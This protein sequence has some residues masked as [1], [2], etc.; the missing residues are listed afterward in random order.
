MTASSP[1]GPSSRPATARYGMAS[2]RT[3]V[4]P[5]LPRARHRPKCVVGYPATRPTFRLDTSKP[6]RRVIVVASI[7]LPE[8]QPH[9]FAEFRVQVA[10]VRTLRPVRGA[11]SPESGRPIVLAGDLN[12]VPTDFDI[13]NP[14]LVARRRGDATGSTRER[15]RSL[16]S[17]GWLD[18]ARHLY[19][20]RADVYLLDNRICVPAKQGNAVGLPTSER[21][22]EVP[23]NQ[24][25]CRRSISWGTE[26][27]RPRPGMDRTDRLTVGC[28][29][30]LCAVAATP[31][32]T[33]LLQRSGMCPL[34]A[35]H[36]RG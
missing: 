36:F 14:R 28:G 29:F 6:R 11:A 25:G 32:W 17:H 33:W 35:S 31:T 9:R 20:H 19:P 26:T 8:W 24:R 23:P 10:V 2:D 4:S 22:A 12:V 1:F 16:L 15:I 13:Y 34:L 5:F 21:A 27:E 18:T 7:Y 3:T 30:S